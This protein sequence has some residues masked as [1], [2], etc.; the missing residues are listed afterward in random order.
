MLRIRKLVKG[1][2]EETWLRVRNEAFREYDDFRPST[3]EDMEIWEKD[4]GFDVEGVFIAEIGGEAI[5]RIQAYIEKNARRRRAMSA[6]SAL[7]P[8]SDVKESVENWQRRRL[9]V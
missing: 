5:G 8:D 4:P 6:V 1:E 3:V 9:T 7:F 2:D